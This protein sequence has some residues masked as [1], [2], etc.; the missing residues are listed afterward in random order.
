[1]IVRR[2]ASGEWRVASGEWQAQKRG[3]AL[4]L[5][6]TYALRVL[7]GRIYANALVATSE[8]PFANLPPFFAE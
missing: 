6:Q 1:M 4:H 2:V 8:K 7:L 3:W 5:S